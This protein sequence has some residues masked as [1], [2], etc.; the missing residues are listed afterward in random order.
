MVEQ[1]DKISLHAEGGHFLDALESQSGLGSLEACDVECAA[2]LQLGDGSG[3]EGH[4][5]VEGDGSLAEDDIQKRPHSLVSPSV[6]SPPLGQMASQG[7]A[8]NTDKTKTTALASFNKFVAASG[9]VCLV[10]HECASS[11]AAG[12]PVG[13]DMS[14]LP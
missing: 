14:L 9:G 12:R 10:R 7:S 11:G 8:A 4:R 5:L 6:L 13:V 2:A 1:D 3:P